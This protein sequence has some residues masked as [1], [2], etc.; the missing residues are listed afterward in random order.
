MTVVQTIQ[1]VRKE[2][3]VNEHERHS[4]Y[5]LG[6]KLMQRNSIFIVVLHF[7]VT[8]TS[9]VMTITHTLELV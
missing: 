3:D 4:K 9:S 1:L 7:K 2:I 5:T 8:V 6:H